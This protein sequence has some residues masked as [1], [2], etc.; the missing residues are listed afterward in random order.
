MEGNP[1][2]AGEAGS[3][4]TECPFCGEMILATASKCRYC[5]EWLLEGVV[6]KEVIKYP[7]THQSYSSMHGE[8]VD[9]WTCL[10]EYAESPEKHRKT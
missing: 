4:R 6:L 8:L 5:R 10:V 9:D 7:G 1:Q 2:P 3:P